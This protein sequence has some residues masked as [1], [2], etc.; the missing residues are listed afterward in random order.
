[1]NKCT[2][3]CEEHIPPIERVII[4]GFGKPFTD[5][6]C[7]KAIEVDRGNGFIIRTFTDEPEA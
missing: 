2:G 1:M 3:S 7:Q 5:Y 4:S 6:Y